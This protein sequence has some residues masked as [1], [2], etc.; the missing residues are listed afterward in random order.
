MKQMHNEQLKTI[1]IM[2][3]LSASQL[4]KLHTTEE[5][6]HQSSTITFNYEYFYESNMT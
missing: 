1:K 6:K 3:K 2:R 4:K 5:K